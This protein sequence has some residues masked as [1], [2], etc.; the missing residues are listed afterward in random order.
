M[1]INS[2]SRE[3]NISGYVDRVEKGP[4]VRR[5]NTRFTHVPEPVLIQRPKIEDFNNLI[6]VHDQIETYI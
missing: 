2:I 4:Y 6:V 3:V 1:R 5:I